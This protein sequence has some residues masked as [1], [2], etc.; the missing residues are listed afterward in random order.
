[1]PSE[2]FLPA[3]IVGLEALGSRYLILKLQSQAPLSFKPGQYTQV[4]FEDQDGTFKKYY[5]IASAPRPDHR[6]ELCVMMDDVRLQRWALQQHIGSLLRLAPPAGRF[7]IP[8]QDQAVVMLAGG[9]GITPLKSILEARVAS[10]EP[11]PTR[12]LYGCQTDKEIPFRAE[13]LALEA[14]CPNLCVSIYADHV[15][16]G[17]AQEGRPIDHL[18]ASLLPDAEYLLCGPAGLMEAAQSLLHSLGVPSDRIH[19]DRF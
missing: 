14:G 5:S 10:G 9:S 13:L 4:L 7:P 19:K 8:R 1:M 2:E 6:L 16:M 17:L 18:S 12:L 3:T 15:A 11:A